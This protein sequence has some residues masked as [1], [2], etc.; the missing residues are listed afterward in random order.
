MDYRGQ[1]GIYV[2]IPFKEDTTNIMD[3]ELATTIN[4][5]NMEDEHLDQEKLPSSTTNRNSNITIFPISHIIET[6]DTNFNT[7]ILITLSLTI[8]LLSILTQ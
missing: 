1:Q 8:E 2:Q 3:Y 4:N 6:N 5:E 7:T